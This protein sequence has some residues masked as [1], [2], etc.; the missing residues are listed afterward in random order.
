M[1]Y[2]KMDYND[3]RSLFLAHGVS[4]PRTAEKFRQIFGVDP[5]LLLKDRGEREY[6]LQCI[7]NY[8]PFYWGQITDSVPFDHIAPRRTA[9]IDDKPVTDT[10][11]TTT[12]E[13]IL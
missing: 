10:L 4:I 9:I 13:D 8:E 3:L 2:N 12:I 11:T 5:D 7:N 6:F 1:D